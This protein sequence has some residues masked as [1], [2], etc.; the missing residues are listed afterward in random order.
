MGLCS[1]RLLRRPNTQ[2]K[3]VQTYS[4][5][6]SG[7]HFA[8]HAL[9]QRLLISC[10]CLSDALLFGLLLRSGIGEPVHC[11]EPVEPEVLKEDCMRNN[12]HLFEQLKEDVHEKE[13]MRLTA[14][15]A[16]L[17]RM[18]EPALGKHSWS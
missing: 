12:I 6:V 14:A 13:L 8:L 10:A 4:E 16:R 15:G 3:R 17:G 9:L 11:G 1:I 5:R 7:T 2:T 18:T